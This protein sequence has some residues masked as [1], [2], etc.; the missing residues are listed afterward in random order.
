MGALLV[1]ALVPLCIMA[2]VAYY[3]GQTILKDNAGAKLEELAAQTM[4]KIDRVL[5]SRAE[6]LRAWAAMEAMQ[7]IASD[8]ADGRITLT[9]VRLWSEYRHEGSIYCLNALGQIVAASEVSL[10]GRTV[11]QTPW[12]EDIRRAE[13]SLITDLAYDPLTRSV[14][15]RLSVPIADTHDDQRV[16]GYLVAHVPH[17]EL[18]QIL[19]QVKVHEGAQTPTGHVVL[20][21]RQFALIA[22]PAFLIAPLPTQDFPGRQLKDIGYVPA[23]SRALST[24][25]TYLTPSEQFLVGYARSSGYRTYDGLGWSTLVVQDST[26][27]F[28]QIKMLRREFL[29]L[30]AVTI[31]CVFLVAFAISRSIFIPI[32]SLTAAANRIAAG[33]LTQ[34]IRVESGDE[35]GALAVSFNRMTSDLRRSRNELVTAN[36]EL[37]LAR[38]RAVEVSDLK[39]R[40]LANMSHEIR[41]PMNGILGM[42]ELTLA[43]AL[44]ARQRRLLDTA[45]RSGRALLQIIND[46]LDFSKIEAGKLELEVLSFHIRQVLS[47]TL[48]L[49]TDR[50]QQ[51]GLSLTG[52]IDE[53]VPPVLYGDP[54]RLRQILTNLIGNATKFTERGRVEVHMSADR[55]TDTQVLLRCTI[56]DTGIGIPQDVQQTIFEPFS[57]ADGSSTRRYGG[58]GLGLS[59]VRQLVTLMGGE[60][61]LRSAP[62]EG[63]T[64][65]FTACFHTVEDADL[66]RASGA[67]LAP[68][69][70]QQAAEQAAVL[71]GESPPSKEQPIPPGRILVAEDNEVNQE[72]ARLML[73]QL[74]QTVEV[75]PDGRAALEALERKRYDAVFLDCQMPV[76]DGLSTARAIREREAREAGASRL[77][78]IALTAHALRGDDEGCAAAGMDDYLSKPFSQA[79]LAGKLRRWLTGPPAEHPRPTASALPV[80]TP[81]SRSSPSPESPSHDSVDRKVW[82]EIARLNQPGRPDVL[83]TMLSIFLKDSD[84]LVSQLQQAVERRDAQT[85]FELAHS[86][87]SRSGALGA[88]KLTAFCREL[89]RLAKTGDLATASSQVEGLLNEF[90]AVTALFRNEIANRST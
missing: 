36:H 33:D 4:D 60:I 63:A 71:G 31:L 90:L 61:S 40:F 27:A 9:L 87:K 30:L 52:T 7:D 2:G 82:T 85:T 20:V 67:R 75:V 77:P 10:I 70:S 12:F 54:G 18:Q 17:T 22:G 38:D 6:D 47:E 35:V 3:T 34:T 46:I 84:Q 83:V 88:I 86:L 37:R 81:A 89:E 51:K 41:T 1:L 73:E 78:L 32:H 58:T 29:A 16:L 25:G 68:T 11:R 45:H 72:V 26:E 59:I 15:V 8:D 28:G 62:G 80:E 13:G 23:G 19:Q 65:T 5:F 44:T 42:T 56:A 79:Q 64:F 76:L 49:F 14:S 69:S 55:G 48:D 53:V 39:S 21:N 74:G 57:Q 43:T 24:R 50:V 66:H